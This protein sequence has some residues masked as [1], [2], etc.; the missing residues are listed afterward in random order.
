L[1]LSTIPNLIPERLPI[2]DTLNHTF[3]K[4]EEVLQTIAAYPSN[5]GSY[6]VARENLGHN[7]GLL[8]AAALMVA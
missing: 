6:T 2:I 4:T 3:Q 5:G 1:G 8:A 7:A